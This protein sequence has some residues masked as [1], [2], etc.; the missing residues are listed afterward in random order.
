MRTEGICTF[1]GLLCGD[2]GISA[3]SSFEATKVSLQNQ[4]D[5]GWRGFQIATPTPSWHLSPLHH[6]KPIEPAF[7]T[8]AVA[9]LLHQAGRTLFAGL[10]TDVGGIRALLDV[11][12]RCGGIVDHLHSDALQVNL[13]LL[14]QTGWISTTLSEIRFRAD[15][16]VLVG[17]H[18]LDRFPRLL[19][20]LRGVGAALERPAQFFHLGSDDIDFRS[21]ALLRPDVNALSIRKSQWLSL[22]QNMRLSLASDEGGLV[23][24]YPP[25]L[26]KLFEALR[27]SSYSAWIWSAADFTS[28]SEELVLDSI[29]QLVR[30]LNVKQ[31]SAILPLAGSQGD[32]TAMQVCSWK[33]G[34]PLRQYLQQGTSHYEP[35]RYRASD[36]MS[37]SDCR[38]LFYVSTFEPV[39]PPAEFW[40]FQGPKV[41]LGHPALRAATKVDYFL[42]TGIPGID[43]DSHLFR[44]DGVS[45][46]YAPAIRSPMAKAAAQWLQEIGQQQDLISSSMHSLELPK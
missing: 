35:R 2:V 6:G 46:L 1:C 25:N 11:A 32:T 36:V 18:L 3:T 34:F 30:Q 9:H 27:Q 37:Q 8:R 28:E 40:Q 43:H 13:D 42:P 45:V 17:D 5:R 14:Q 29:N 16:I 24:K 22:L 38:C 20:R 19:E 41:V 4:C 26:T 39:E 10:A 12:D 33:T 44:G 7:A 21:Q 23:D 31:R 15:V